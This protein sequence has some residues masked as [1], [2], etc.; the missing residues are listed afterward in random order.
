MSN[1]APVVEHLELKD[2]SSTVI[3]DNR[4][5]DGLSESI[6]IEDCEHH[7]HPVQL[8]FAAWHDYFYP[9]LLPP[10]VQLC[11]LENIC[12][13]ACYLTV[14]ILQGCIR[15]L[16]NVY[17][18]DLGAN[19]A[20]QTT[21]ASIA[22]LPSAFKI[23]FGFLSDTVPIAG[24]RRKPY[25]LAAWLFTTLLMAVLLMFCDLT[26]PEPIND[27]NNDDDT[28]RDEPHIVGSAANR[29]PTIPFLTLVFFATGCGIWMADAMIDSFVAQKARLEPEHAQGSLQSTCYAVRFF[30]IAVVAPLSTYLYSHVNHGRGP[31]VIVS[32]IL[33]VPL[34]VVAPLWVRL[35]EERFEAVPS[36][37]EQCREIW[38]TVCSRAVWQPMGFVYVYNLLQVP[39]AAWRQFLM[40][41]L[42]FSASQLN[43][44]LTLSY[45]MLY[46][47]VVAYQHCCLRASWQRL[48]TVCIAVTALFS[49]T[50]LALIRGF[51]MGLDPFLFALGDDAI[52]EFIYGIQMLPVAM[53]M[54]RLCPVHSEGASYAMFTTTWNS[55]MMMAQAIA[56]SLLLGIWDVSKRTMVSGDLDGLFRLSLLTTLI[57]LSP[58]MVVHWFP[59]DRDGLDALADRRGSE[60]GGGLF[61]FVVASSVLYSLRVALLNV[62]APG[63]A[64]ET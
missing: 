50:Q 26:R 46:F 9:P 28:N 13:P 62:V 56:S 4:H 10:E 15:P 3:D 25:L 1:T 34:C 11:R 63:W 38:K 64:G 52:T 48:Y 35:R 6:C 49:L 5:T 14:G 24:Y 2:P 37:G 58:L 33:A 32:I 60:L 43:V 23:V 41:V 30:G 42:G 7:E 55:A 8:S 59:H 61:L 51:T 47:G 45:V 53:V 54:V 44:L 39:N 21:L 31:V 22:M 40:S 27:P 17:P 19:E 20:Q 18:I 29:R 16:L 57:K 36:A 12:I